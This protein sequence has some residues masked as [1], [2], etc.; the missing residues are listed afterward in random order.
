MLSPF[1][2]GEILLE[3]ISD[4]QA[5]LQATWFLGDSAL[6]KGIQD[7]LS[8]SLLSRPAATRWLFPSGSRR[9][10]TTKLLALRSLLAVFVL[11]FLALLGV[12]TRK[13]NQAC[14]PL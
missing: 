9:A 3:T 2:L 6:S 4:M 7:L 13:S 5:G 11:C 10:K 1:S 14:Y 8:W 12:G